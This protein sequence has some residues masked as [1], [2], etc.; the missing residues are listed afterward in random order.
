M[1]V[2]NSVTPEAGTEALAVKVT[3]DGKLGARFDNSG[4]RRVGTTSVPTVAPGAAAGTAPSA[5]GVVGTDEHGV[6]SATIGT[7]PA[8][9]IVATVTFNRA[10]AVIPLVTLTAG[11]AD[12]AG[13]KLWATATTTT[14]VIHAAASP[15]AAA[16]W[17][18]NYST[19]GQA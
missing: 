17:K 2:F 5:V 13:A 8:A 11:D 15:T 4:R 3:P 18:V 12:S 6:V 10:Y 14:L 19:V 9:G 16:V 7:S 1:P